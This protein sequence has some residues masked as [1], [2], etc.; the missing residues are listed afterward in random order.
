M[1]VNTFTS[2]EPLV[3]TAENTINS[4][5]ERV[6]NL[7]AAAPGS[8]LLAA[9]NLSDV[10]SAATALTNLGAGAVGADVFAG[11]DAAAVWTALGLGDYAD[12]AAA[13]LGGVAVGEGYHTAGV[14]KT[15]MV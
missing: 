1:A 6:I 13:A 9:N 3:I 2:Q 4:A 11:A 14:L 10:D 15:R 8:A 7:T 12:D 5:G